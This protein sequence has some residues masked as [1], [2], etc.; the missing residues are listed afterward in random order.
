MTLV[1]KDIFSLNSGEQDPALLG[2]WDTQQFFKGATKLRNC[3]SLVTGGIVRRPGLEYVD[4]LHGAP[5][6]S[7]VRARFIPYLDGGIDSATGKP[8]GALIV[9]GHGRIRIYN[10][11]ALTIAA[12]I[13]DSTYDLIQ[14]E[15]TWTQKSGGDDIILFHPNLQP[16]RLSIAT[17]TRLLST[18]SFESIPQHRFRYA[19]GSAAP[20]VHKLQLLNCSITD[21]FIN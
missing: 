1:S 8:T 12:T 9:I 7:D 6:N 3:Y 4:D 5:P 10:V 21:R 13:V 11:P 16:R 2:R 18:L 17:G 15:I 19:V 14:G 20:H